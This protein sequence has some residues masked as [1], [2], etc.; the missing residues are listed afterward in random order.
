VLEQ[1]HKQGKAH[2]I[3]VSN[4]SSSHL[5]ELLAKAAVKPAVNQVAT[6]DAAC[7][8]AAQPQLEAGMCMVLAAQCNMCQHRLHMAASIQP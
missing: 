6:G 3:G 7:A 4:Y 8:A 2:A 5:Q 1:L